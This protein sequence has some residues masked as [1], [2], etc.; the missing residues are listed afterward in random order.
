MG[1]AWRMG[2][3]ALVVFAMVWLVSMWRWQ[4]QEVDVQA[5]D[6]ALH[7]LAL[8]LGLLCV[9]W[10]SLKLADRVRQGVLQPPTAVPDA[11]ASKGAQAQLTA[12]PD[13]SPLSPFAIRHA[14]FCLPAGDDAQ[15]LLAQI[16]EHQARP[17]LDPELVDLDGAAV[18]S[19]R[20]A[21]VDEA[22]SEAPRP[23]ESTW[24]PRMHRAEVL[25]VRTWSAMAETL[26]DALPAMRVAG[27]W[28]TS[29]ANDEA[30][31]AAD[32]PAGPAHLAGVA[33]TSP[34]ARPI[35]PRLD[36]WV[37]TPADWLESTQYAW[38]RRAQACALQTHPACDV[39]W[40][41]CP[42][43]HPD[44]IWGHLRSAVAVSASH[45]GP[46]SVVLLAADSL[47]D[48][49]TVDLWQSRGELFTSFHQSGRI[50]GEG[51]V[52]L[53]LSTADWPSAQVEGLHSEA[54][55]GLALAEPS[56]AQRAHS[57]DVRG[58]V[59][60]DALKAC[61]VAAWPQ[62]PQPV[63][64]WSDADHRASRASELFE[65]LQDTWPELDLSTQV[66]RLGDACGDLGLVRP[67]APLAVAVAL[68]EPAL[69]VLVHDP[70]RRAVVSIKPHVESEVVK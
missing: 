24:S 14:V 25:M 46:R 64:V 12:D 58:R 60:T 36:V 44:D 51:A 49:A 55:P 68:G 1:K 10:V 23:D 26:I 22:L 45:A 67:L 48:E 16:A 41:L 20:I 9:G 27:G 29:A 5:S 19:A 59:G 11:A 3:M 18:F 47:I 17:D 57:A 69:V 63:R 38:M 53:W 35:V 43:H 31:H 32:R 28:D 37:V 52:A 15:G 34:K 33:S 13:R 56:H 42:V 66:I 21:A 50:P 65:S 8:P 54:R 7:L 39:H 30:G 6:L 40:H 61:L 62:A 70:V 2:L 4:T